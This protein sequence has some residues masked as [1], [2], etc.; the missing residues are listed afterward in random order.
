MVL[1]VLLLYLPTLRT[2][3]L[4]DDFLDAQTE[5]GDAHLAFSSMMSSGYRPL[6]SYSWG[7]DNLVWGR[8]MQW[9]WHLTNILILFAALYSLRRF[10]K[11]FISCET[12]VLAGVALFALCY[13][14]ALSV[15]KVVWRTSLLPLIPLLWAMVLAVEYEK[16]QRFLF[17]AAASF[18]LLVSLLLKETALASAPVFGVLTWS[19][20]SGKEQGRAFLRGFAAAAVAT[21]VYIVL[22]L[23]AVGLVTGYADSASFSPLMLK[24]IALLFSM[25]WSP[26]LDSVP[27]RIL[28]PLQIMVLILMPASGKLKLFIGSMSV[29]LLLTA[30]NLSP[31]P[32]YA[33]PGALAAALAVAVYGEAVKK[34][35]AVIPLY[36]LLLLGVFL[37]SRDQL[38]ILGEAS[39]MV[40]SQT[41]LMAEIADEV[42]GESP[43][44]FRGVPE[45]VAGYSTFWGEEYMQP[46]EYAGY[47]PGRFVTGVSGMWELLLIHGE[48]HIIFLKENS[49]QSYSVSS[50]GYDES[51]SDTSVVLR[52]SLQA[53][54]LAQYPSCVVGSADA[55]VFLLSPIHGDSLIR[56][57]AENIDH[58]QVIDLASVPEWIADGSSAVLVSDR[59]VELVFSSRNIAAENAEE[60]LLRK[61]SEGH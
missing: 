48:G 33:V 37:Q 54:L 23:L 38:K 40:V 51:L 10:L 17:A 21:A 50:T 27:V 30:S 3:F 47:N 57:E 34:R 41:A 16:E 35:R 25:V 46:L 12:S 49:W 43:L 42:P 29:F 44:F 22:R 7:L 28:L 61:A 8:R 59:E 53:G 9:G 2:G 5:T 32:D 24:N 13:P 19:V 26:W 18:L 36:G 31:R 55:A 39:D 56:L 58:Q 15:G 60:R 20:S 1:L 4:S 52:Q 6:M 14:V 45:A 11:L